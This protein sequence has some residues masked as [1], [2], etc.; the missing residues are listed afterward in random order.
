MTPSIRL[1][2]P[3][4]PAILRSIE[5]H[6]HLHCHKWDTQV[7]DTQILF[8]QPL[9][10]SSVDWH[11]LCAS[12]EQ[13]AKE[14]HHLELE[15][16][17]SPHSRKLL[18]LPKPLEEILKYY[19]P[20]SPAHGN[21]VRSLRFDFHPT[22]DGWRVSEVNSDVPGG[23][24]EATFLP[25][26]YRPFYSDLISPESPLSV[27]GSAMQ[28]AVSSGNVA[29]LSAPGYLEDQQVIRVLARE[30]QN[31]KM[32][33]HFI[34]SP[35]ALT[36]DDG[37]ASLSLK[38]SVRLDGVVRF[39]QAEWLCC[40]PRSTGWRD[41]LQSQQLPVTNSTVSVLSESK[42]FPLTWEKLTSPSNVWRSLMPECRNPRD[43][44]NNDWDDWVLKV[45]Y[46]NTGDEIK[47]C[48]LLPQRERQRAIRQALS[49]PH[50][51]VAQKRFQTQPLE[52]VRGP[53]YPC[54]GIFV[55]NGKAAGTYVR[56]SPKQITDCFAWETPAF[57]YEGTLPS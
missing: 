26:L 21:S 44:G 50:S 15:L 34:Q 43:V 40:L 30:L 29:F 3:I 33:C 16:L 11:W 31:R 5:R 10:I 13:L 14:T 38:T 48:G 37:R 18:S 47:I 9:I 22:R 24:G 2:T 54:V 8:E 42:R 4:P 57:V 56:L 17:G 53:V 52:S 55:I 39:Y 46:T 7:G 35:A 20:C 28:L 32:C 51:W 25:Q 1:G 41:L 12:A 49:R 19:N 45:S 36:W 27:W 6:L 23:F